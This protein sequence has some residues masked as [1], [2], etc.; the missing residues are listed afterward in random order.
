MSIEIIHCPTWA[1]YKPKAASFAAE[2]ESTTGEKVYLVEGKRGQFDIVVD[3]KVVAKRT[4]N[5]FSK[6][7][8]KMGWPTTSDVI[9][10]VRMALGQRKAA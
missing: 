7:I 1:A 4:G 2:I 10:A 8:L 3:G 5:F 9:A 6:V